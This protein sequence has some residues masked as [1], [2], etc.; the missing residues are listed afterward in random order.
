MASQFQ[1]QLEQQFNF[2][3]HNIRSVAGGDINEARKLET[4]RGDFFLKFNAAPQAAEMFAT[5]QG[6]LEALAATK[7]IRIPEII[8]RGQVENY[9]FL[10]LE[11]IPKGYT[12]ER[13]WEQFGKA[14]ATL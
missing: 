5:E 6:G 1:A 9:A 11:F 3:I 4:D 14:L 2:S 13:F 7:T 8:G 10:L 12:D